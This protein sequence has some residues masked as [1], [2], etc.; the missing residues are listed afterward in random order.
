MRLRLLLLLLALLLRDAPRKRASISA[1]F[2]SS[3]PGF[4]ML[5]PAIWEATLEQL[6]GDSAPEFATPVL[7]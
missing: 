3:P 1:K 4:D 5:F 7:Y 6:H 2:V